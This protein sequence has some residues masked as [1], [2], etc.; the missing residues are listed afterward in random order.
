MTRRICS[1]PI[2]L[3]GLLLGI[4]LFAL[5]L[6]PSAVAQT[7][8]TIDAGTPITVRTN[9]FIDAEY[10]DGQ[11]FSGTV[12]QDVEDQYG[13]V[14][15]PRGT[16]VQMVVR[17]ISSN[18]VALDLDQIVVYGEHFDVSAGLATPNSGRRVYTRGRSVY[19]PTNTSL[20]FRL[21]QPLRLGFGDTRRYK[22][23]YNDDYN[24]SA[25]FRAGMAAGRSDAERNLTRNPRTSRWSG[26]QDRRDFEAGYN[27]AYDDR[28]RGSFPASPNTNTARISI[29]GD[30]NVSWQSPVDA[31]VFVQVDNNP[32]QLFAAGASGN[33]MAS[34]IQP[35]HVYVFVM[36][37]MNGNEIARHQLDLRRTRNR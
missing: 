23:G 35:G 29:G 16:E 21:Q 17:D 37:D 12:Q 4:T 13:N 5:C 34:W 24:N 6:A 11:V 31:R 28:I 36:R 25:A 20:T 9:Q 18:Q 2:S 19:V 27:R 7:R 3:A 22:P 1:T 30:N 10:S 14:A 32:V 33:Q 26:Y 15:I 8:M